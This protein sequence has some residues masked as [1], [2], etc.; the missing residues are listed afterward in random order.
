MASAGGNRP[1]HPNRGSRSPSKRAGRDSVPPEPTWEHVGARLGHLLQL[2][3][4]CQRS[5]AEFGRYVVCA[6][7]S[8]PIHPNRGT[9]LPPKGLGRDP[10]PKI[11]PN[12][13]HRA[14]AGRGSN[15]RSR[16]YRAT[17][18][19]A[20]FPFQRVGTEASRVMAAPE[21]QKLLRSRWRTNQ[22]RCSSSS[23]GGRGGSRDAPC[24]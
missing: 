22:G 6:G 15:A 3:S 13:R 4:G 11:R 16:P 10:A 12:R 7:G 20:T 14:R 18:L 8:R 19:S 17:T 1:I 9:G 2:R 24:P 21:D 5:V 23:E